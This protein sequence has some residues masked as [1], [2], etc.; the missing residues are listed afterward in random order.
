[1]RHLSSGVYI[2]ISIGKALFNL[3]QRTE[4][5]IVEFYLGLN[6]WEGGLLEGAC[7]I[8]IIYF[9]PRLC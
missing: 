7:F 1:M 6:C 9:K 4:V 5:A 3:S 8:E 2:L